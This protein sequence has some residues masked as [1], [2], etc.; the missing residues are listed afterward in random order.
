MMSTSLE[1][2]CFRI[3][4]MEV[5]R[6]V[7]PSTREKDPSVIKI[8]FIRI[9]CLKNKLLM[10]ANEASFRKNKKRILKLFIF[11]FATYVIID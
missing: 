1:A 2:S 6:F 8:V 3:C 10:R 5:K 7:V 4:R 9:T 11:R